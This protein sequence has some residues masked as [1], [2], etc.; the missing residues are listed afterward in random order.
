MNRVEQTI[1]KKSHPMYSIINDFCIK[2]TNMYNFANYHVRKR[3]IEDNYWLKYQEMQKIFKTEEPYKQL[4]SQ[5]SQ[6]I[7]QVLERDWKSFFEGMKAWKSNPSKFLGMPKLPKYKPKGKPSTWFLKNNNTYIKEGRLYFRLKAMQGFSFKTSVKDRLIAIRFVPKNGVIILEIIYEKI[8]T[9]NKIINNNIISLDLGVNNFVTMTN[10][11]GKNPILI[12]GK[13]IKSINQHYNK[14]RSYLTSTLPNNVFWSKKLNSITNNRNNKVKNF[15]HHS[16]KYI[17][18]YCKENNISKIII[19]NNPMWKQDIKLSKR[20]NQNFV[21]IPYDILIKQL[22]YKSL[23]YGI[24]VILTEESYTSGTSFLDNELPIKEN[25][26]KKRRI[27]RGLFK[28]NKG[29]LINSDVNGSYQIMKKVFP[30]VFTN[31]IEACLT[32]IKVNIL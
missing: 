19:G 3:F 7:L 16:S 24:E 21:S 26:N 4:M 18:K 6:C 10:N 23:D 15:I 5:S 14:Q 9:T 11:I 17:L 29:I 2:S 31:G 28:S 32:P 30:N 13:Q 27:K 8:I 12:N 25:Y 1:I 22:Q 20:T